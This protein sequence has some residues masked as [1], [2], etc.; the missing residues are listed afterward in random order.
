MAYGPAIKKNSKKPLLIGIA[1]VGLLVVVGVGYVWKMRDTNDPV[2]ATSP[3]TNVEEVSIGIQDNQTATPSPIQTPPGQTPAAE[4]STAI[5]I[6]S[7]SSGETVK[8]GTKLVG[9]APSVRTVSYRIQSDDRGL[10]GQGDLAVV[11]NKFSG[12]L[13]ATGAAGHCCSALE[14]GGDPP[15]SRSRCSVLG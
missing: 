14:G 2:A 8:A 12:T 13:A 7:P 11:N 4:S 9:T 15:G 3:Q 5:V 6:T 1:I 10:V